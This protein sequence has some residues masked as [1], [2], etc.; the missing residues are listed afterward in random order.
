MSTAPYYDLLERRKIRLEK[1]AKLAELL[2][3]EIEEEISRAENRSNAI[4]I[5][6][7]SDS[8][9][10]EQFRYDYDLSS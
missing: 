9:C 7:L 6:A 2:Q 1:V 8:E 10:D 5:S 4:D 3:T